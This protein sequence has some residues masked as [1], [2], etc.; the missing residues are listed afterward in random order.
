MK[1]F[2]SC[3]IRIPLVILISPVVFL[4]LFL[5]WLAIPFALAVGGIMFVYEIIMCG[6][7][8]IDEESV[9]PH[10]R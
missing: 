4:I 1:A 7:P 3:L 2:W 9:Q 6:E 5:A 10:K 8:R